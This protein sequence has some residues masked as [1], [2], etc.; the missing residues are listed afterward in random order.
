MSS[1]ES[2]EP[3]APSLEQSLSKKAAKKEAAKQDKL[4][5]RQ[6]ASL[7]TA[8]AK[9]AVDDEDPLAGNYG[10][11]PIEELQS[12][13]VVDAAGWTRVEHLEASLAGKEVLIRGRAQTIRP[14]GKKMAFLVVRENGFTV[15][16]LVQVQAD[17]VST[18]MVKYA[19]A[20]SRESVID[21]EGVVS[22]PDAP[23]KG[24]T[25]QVSGFFCS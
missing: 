2:Q 8:A 13:T 6:E 1:S 10:D 16:C 22:V 24:A 9:L 3:S 4:R 15:Q 20:L 12:K 5:R 11:I 18:Q 25:Q 23:I 7:A 17:V 21:V 14:V 19:A